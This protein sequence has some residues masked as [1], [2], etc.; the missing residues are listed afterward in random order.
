MTEKFSQ[1]NKI[2][3]ELI[4]AFNRYT[5]E[6]TTLSSPELNLYMPKYK[7]NKL[8]RKFRYYGAKI[9]HSISHDLSLTI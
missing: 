6:T 3:V 4:L 1:I 7:T 9:L 5:Y 8:Q 2:F